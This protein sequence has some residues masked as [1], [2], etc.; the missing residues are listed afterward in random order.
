VRG[1]L[2]SSRRSSNANDV[3]RAR[4]DEHVRDAGLREA[5]GCSRYSEW[6]VTADGNGARR[7]RLLQRAAEL[8]AIH[9]RNAQIGQHRRWAQARAFSSA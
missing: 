2:L 6:P 1:L 3:G 9:A 5:I 8:E 4:F 7:R